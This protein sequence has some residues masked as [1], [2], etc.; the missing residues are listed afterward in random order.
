L[1]LHTLRR[2]VEQSDSLAAYAVEVDALD[3]SA[4]ASY[5]KYGLAPLLDRPKH[6]YLPLATIQ[7]VLE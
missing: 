3:D 4:V 1:L 5:L 7:T 2:S 6:L